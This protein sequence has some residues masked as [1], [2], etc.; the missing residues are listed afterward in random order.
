MENWSMDFPTIEKWAYTEA[1]DREFGQWQEEDY[2]GFEHMVSSH[3][4]LSSLVRFAG[5]PACL[6]RPFFAQQLVPYL[7]WI[8]GGGPGLP[9]NFSRFAGL[10]SREKFFEQSVQYAEEIYEIAEVIEKMRCS[11]DSLLQ[12]LA[13]IIYEFRNERRDVD[14]GLRMKLARTLHAKVC[15]IYPR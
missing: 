9:F 1:L 3:C 13:D 15:D 14:S 8:F 10:V 6:K 12:A 11:D 5:D 7:S 4:N 2:D